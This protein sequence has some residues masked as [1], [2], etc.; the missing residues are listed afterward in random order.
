MEDLKIDTTTNSL[1]IDMIKLQKMA[2]IYN[3]LEN[4]WSVKK[5]TEKDV[6]IFTKNHGGKKEVYLDSYLRRFMEDNF[7]INNIISG[8][9]NN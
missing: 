6:Y 7:N 2:L 9:T 4:G 8:N 1:N 5:N 3:S